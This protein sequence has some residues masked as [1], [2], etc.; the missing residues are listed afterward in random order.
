[1]SK[2]IYMAHTTYICI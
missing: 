2:Y 1:M